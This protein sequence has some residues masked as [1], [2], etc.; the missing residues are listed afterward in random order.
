MSMNTMLTYELD[1]C[2]LYVDT[3]DNYKMLQ[4]KRK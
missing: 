2:T 4:G 1:E 3:F